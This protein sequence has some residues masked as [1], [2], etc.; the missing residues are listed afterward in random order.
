MANAT[1]ILG[2]DGMGEV[3]TEADFDAWVAYVCEHIDEATGLDVAVETRGKRDVQDDKILADG[4]G[5][6]D[7]LTIDEALGT[8]W[9]AFCASPELWPSSAHELADADGDQAAQ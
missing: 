7:S 1:L 8:L 9:E 2:R 3:A 5:S 4:S 6:G